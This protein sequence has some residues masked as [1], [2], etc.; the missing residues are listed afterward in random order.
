[1]PG[2]RP[3]FAYAIPALFFDRFSENESGVIF[4][5]FFNRRGREEGT[6]NTEI[7]Q[8]ILCDPCALP[9]IS[10]VRNIPGF[11]VLKLRKLTLKCISHGMSHP[12]IPLHR[13][14]E[15]EN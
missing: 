13:Q 8:D 14:S 11:P 15:C 7:C 6:E 1:M 2:F 3:G 4:F 12:E 5:S 9:V 10:A